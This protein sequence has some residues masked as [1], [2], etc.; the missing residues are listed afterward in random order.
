MAEELIPHDF[1]VSPELFEEYFFRQDSH[2]NITQLA[3]E[4][5]LG[6]LKN[7][8]ISWRIF[9]GIL[10]NSGPLDIWINRLTELRGKYQQ[11]I[12]EQRVIS[13]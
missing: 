10:P 3:N 5:K 6:T 9:L 13:I 11:M 12:D 2:P 8:F 7:R 4:G 1:L